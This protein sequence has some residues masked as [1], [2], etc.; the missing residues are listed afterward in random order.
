[1][2]TGEFSELIKSRR[3]IRA[4]QDKPVPEELLL[5][6]VELAAWAPNGANAQMWYFYIVLDKKLI[7][8]I[9][10]GAQE[11]M[12]NMSSWPEMAKGGGFPTP[13]PPPPGQTAPPPPRR[14]PL[15]DS[16]AMILVGAKK[17]EN[18]IHKVLAER[19]KVDQRAAQMLEWSI[20]L[21]SGI[22]SVSA[23]IAYLLLALHQMGLGATWMTGPLSQTKG[24]VEKLLKVPS[25]MDI[26][27]LIPVGYPADIPKGFRK[28]V[29][30]V[31]TVIQ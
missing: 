6:A 18:P 28:P 3:S 19:A 27:A 17:R 4:W 15:S 2:D 31:C 29:S 13:P 8:A 26:I 23:G 25:D 12:K 11:S 30:E 20:S 10:D 24:D 16:P 9:G 22:Q 1:V 7:K 5:K 14:S 21:Q